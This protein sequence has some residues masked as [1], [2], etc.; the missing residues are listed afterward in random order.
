ME[1]VVDLALLPRDELQELHGTCAELRGNVESTRMSLEYQKMQSDSEW[2]HQVS[3]RPPL[4]D[5]R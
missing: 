5:T 4:G 3:A 1:R 2:R